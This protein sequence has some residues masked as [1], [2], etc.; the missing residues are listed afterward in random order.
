MAELC[1]AVVSDLATLQEEGYIISTMKQRGEG[2]DNNMMST[3]Q[4]T[5]GHVSL[6]HMP[7]KTVQTQC[8]NTGR[9]SD[10]YA[11]CHP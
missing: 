8:S 6:V 1:K 9:K 4:V 5:W 2:R 7:P 3:G 10:V 11:H